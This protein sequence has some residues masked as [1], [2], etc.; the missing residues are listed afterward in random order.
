[1]TIGHLGLQDLILD[2]D[3]N[4]LEHITI[5]QGD[6]RTRG[7]RVLITDQ[8]G[9]ILTP[10]P[11]FELRLYGTNSNYPDKTYF[12]VAETVGN[13][14]HVYITTDMASAEGTLS[15]QLALFKGDIELIQSRIKE[16]P[17]H[18]SIAQGG[19]VGQD[20]VVD[21]T[22]LTEAIA[23]VGEQEEAY[24]QSLITQEAIRQD[25]Q[26]RQ[27]DVT[28]KHGQVT[29]MHQSLQI[30][31]DSEQAR[32]TAEQGRVSAESTR[33][34]QENTRVSQENTRKSNES[35]RQA[36][37]TERQS[38]ETTR[39][40]Q[41]TARQSAEEKRVSAENIRDEEEEIRKSNEVKREENEVT[42]IA[43]E[44]DRVVA[45]KE[46]ETK[47]AGWDLAME[48][49]IPNAEEDQMGVVKVSPITGEVAPYTVPTMGTIVDRFTATNGAVAG[50]QDALIAGDNITIDPA[51]NTISATDTVYE[52]PASEPMS[53]ITGL[54]ETLDSKV[55]LSRLTFVENDKTYLGKF[56]IDNGQPKIVAEEVV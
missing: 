45:E 6:T 11:G 13:Y 8:S 23:R 2:F 34:S 28:S 20:L 51:T 18:R 56:V 52:K 25:V 3:H 32:V 27:A 37:E 14:Y 40:S 33:V 24:T 10:A 49:V 31:Y 21:F 43:Q 46:R 29:Q 5:V 55:N 19:Q 26:T 16:V 47:F 12:T 53:Y 15:L 30:V 38:N 50:K 22:R 42:R 1:M 48:G 17:V 39:K 4:D 36:S 7:F 35:T 44:K 54:Q 41:E 9:S